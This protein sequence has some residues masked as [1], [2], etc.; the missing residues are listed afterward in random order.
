MSDQASPLI[1]CKSCGNSFHG[2]Y[3]NECGEKVLK[4]ADRSFKTFLS[5]MLIAITF[6]DSKMIKT[7]W[8]VLSKP[9][10]VSKEF[11]EG[12]RVNYLK[13][14]SLF[15]V[16]N[17]IYFFFPL[18]QLFSAS[19]NTQLLSPLRDYYQTVVAH[20]V[21]SMG[22]TVPSFSLIYNLKTTG[23]A[24]LMV[25]VFV[26]I[27]SLPLNVLYWK[28]NRFFT[29]HVGYMVELA[30]F[31]LFVNAI[32]LSVLAFFGLGKYLSEEVLTAIFIATNLY[33]LLRSGNIFYQEKN[34]K[35][36]LKSVMMIAFLKI[37][38]EVYRAILFFVTIWS[39]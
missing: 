27:A 26:V 32:M 36:V 3:C 5:N 25:M 30:C 29:D 10:F 24:K 21:V 12:R 20:K 18:I 17:L 22:M 35:L 19:L 6:A 39:L 11:A 28:R 34:W 13:P 8:L 4:P 38:L 16:L 9:G 15:F 23:F 37:A 31:N 1:V 7:L 14:I 33:F 2:N